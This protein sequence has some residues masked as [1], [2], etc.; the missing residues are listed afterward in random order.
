M[1]L[2]RLLLTILFWLASILSNRPVVGQG[3]TGSTIHISGG[4]PV[5]PEDLDAT[6]DRYR[7]FQH[8]EWQGW[9][10]GSRRVLYLQSVAGTVQAIA[11]EHPGEP[12]TQLTDT[13]SPVAWVYSDPRR[14]RLVIAEDLDGNERYRL[15]LHDLSTGEYHRFTNGLWENSSV[16]WSRSGRMLAL[17]STARNGKDGDLYVIE[18][19]D[20]FD[21][22]AA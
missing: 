3:L 13:H 7:F 1:G 17:T 8:A 4:V 21:G 18:P 19:P 5:V 11:G 15:T 10:A 14:E 12:G 6:I 16:L 9:L 22:P 2:R 20:T